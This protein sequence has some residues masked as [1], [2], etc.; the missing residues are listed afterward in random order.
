MEIRLNKYVQENLWISRRKF[1]DMVKLGKVFVDNNM[2]E[3]YSSVLTGWELLEIRWEKIKQKI[4]LSERAVDIIVFNKPI[5]VVCSK[6]DKHN[7]T[8]YE[9]LPE[10]FANYFYIGRLDKDSRGLL[11]M[12]NDSGMV[13]KFEHPSNKV[14][15]EYV[16]QI[17]RPFSNHDYVKMRKWIVDDG[18]TLEIKSAKFYENRRKC[19]VNIVL[20]EWKKRHIRRM[21]ASLWY[22]VFDLQR[23]REWKFKL[24][25]V[26]ESNWIPWD[27]VMKKK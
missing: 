25:N 11:L 1:V 3:S 14:E 24:G 22:E 26:K 6:S 17:S 27:L 2:I 4:K 19:F 8:I 7:K 20:L 12:T 15:K 13:N 10:K 9:L 5:G 23:V 21:L 16:V 18:D